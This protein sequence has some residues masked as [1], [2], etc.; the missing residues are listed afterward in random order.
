M[1]SKV[2]IYNISLGHIGAGVTIAS[3]TERSEE[4]VICNRFYD[5]A[6]K[7]VLRDFPYS[8]AQARV[9]LANV[10]KPSEYSDFSYAYALPSDMLKANAIYNGDFE[11]IA[12]DSHNYN[13]FRI[14][15]NSNGSNTLLC[16][17]ENCV[18]EYTKDISTLSFTDVS[19]IEMLSYKLASL[20]II[21]LMKNNSSKLQELNQIYAARLANAVQNDANSKKL[22]KKRDTWVSIAIGN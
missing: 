20:I 17:V 21:P 19:F 22:P 9:T 2:E 4:A 16:N 15:A 3:D 5:L 8:F 7:T 13:Y 10:D 14:I 6:R 18:L 12:L 11:R 1:Y